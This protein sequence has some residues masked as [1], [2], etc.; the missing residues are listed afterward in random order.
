MIRAKSKNNNKHLWFNKSEVDSEVKY[1]LQLRK[2]V[3][4]KGPPL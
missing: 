1:Q 2:S 4:Q 3:L